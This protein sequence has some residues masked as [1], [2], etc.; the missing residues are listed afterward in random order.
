VR[1]GNSFVNSIGGFANWSNISDG[2][3]KKN[4]KQ[5]VPGLTFINKLRPVTYNLDLDA[6]DRILQPPVRKDKD[7]KTVV[8]SQFDISARN[9]K[10]QIVY[11][12][13]VAQDVEKAAKELN[14]DFSGIDAAK[15]NKDLYGL[16]YSE[17]VVP[18]VRAVQELSKMNDEKDHIINDLKTRLERL[19]TAMNVQSPPPGS[20][21]K[22]ISINDASLEQNIPNPFSR[23]TTISYTLPQQFNAAKIIIT[24]NSG[25]SIKEIKVSG[26]GKNSLTVDASTL[27]SGTY[28]YS[29]IIDGKLIA[30]RQLMLVK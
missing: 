27:T 21:V 19:E 12:G 20:Q 1:I 2:R 11:T 23:T 5:N 14:Y 29:L 7:G 4:I 22:V 15:S 24:D 17:F 8:P 9:A 18:L 3:V 26:A 10:L 13:F 6:A 28:Q 30:T 16:R 25:K